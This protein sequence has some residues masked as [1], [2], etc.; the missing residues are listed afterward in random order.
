MAPSEPN[1]PLFQA[2]TK[3][4]KKR[5]SQE[6]FSIK[7]CAV[8]LQGENTIIVVYFSCFSRGCVGLAPKW[9]GECQKAS[10]IFRM[11]LCSNAKPV[12]QHNVTSPYAGA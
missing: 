3:E 5:T 8:P 12:P 11:E 6:V 4:L 10:A 1:H 7:G 2:T 9:L